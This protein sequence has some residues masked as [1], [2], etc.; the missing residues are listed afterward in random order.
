MMRTDL[1][2]TVIP[3]NQL[4]KQGMAS[5]HQRGLSHEPLVISSAENN[6]DVFFQAIP[7]FHPT[8]RQE[9]TFPT[10]TMTATV[11]F[12]QSLHDSICSVFLG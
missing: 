5:Y 12:A 8:R 2:F 7:S 9:P 1:G 11:A 10:M 4:S 6:N 3:V